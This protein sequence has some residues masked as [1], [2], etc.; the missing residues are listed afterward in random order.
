MIFFV[1]FGT[2]Y[3]F[4]ALIGI[5]TNVL[6]M[7]DG[8]RRHALYPFS[9]DDII[10]TLLREYSVDNPL[11]VNLDV[12]CTAVGSLSHRNI[13]LEVN[14]DGVHSSIVYDDEGTMETDVQSLLA[15]VLNGSNLEFCEAFVK[16]KS[17]CQYFPSLPLFRIETPTRNEVDV[18]LHSPLC[19]I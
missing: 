5:G 3:D 16:D 7:M 4:S 17:I 8:V 2:G 19:Q 14:V 15:K 6:E 12:H 11:E 18:S 1:D 13:S 9:S 10:R